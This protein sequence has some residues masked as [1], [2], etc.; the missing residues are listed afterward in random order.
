MCLKSIFQ[1]MPLPLPPGGEGGWEVGPQFIFHNWCAAAVSAE[2]AFF[3]GN[4]K[5]NQKKS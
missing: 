2:S 3:A 1:T 4:I 5:P